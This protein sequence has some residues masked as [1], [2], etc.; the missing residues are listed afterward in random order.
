MQAT[1]PTRSHLK[2]QPGFGYERHKPEESD[3]YQVIAQHWPAFQNQ[4]SEADV[5]LPR[6][7]QTEFQSYL[8]CGLLKH[9]FMRVKCNGCRF[10]HLVAFSCKMR[11]FCPACGA[12]RMVETAAHLIDHVLPEV[13]IRQWVLS[14]PWPLRFLF[15]REPGALSRC[16]T[17]IIR[18]LETDLIKRAGLNRASGAK[19]GTVTLIQRFGSAVNLNIHTHL[20][21]LDGVYTTDETGN[22][23]FHRVKAPTQ[24][25]MDTL[26]ERMVQR[27]I[28]TLERDGW[29]VADE[30][31]PWL[32]LQDREPL[33]SLNAASIQYTIALGPG[34]GNRTLTIH[35]PALVRP[36]HPAKALTSNQNGFSLNAAVAC[37]PHQRDKLERLCRYVTR[38]AICL[39]RLTLRADGQVQYQLK[40][41]FRDGTTHILFSPLDFIGKLVALVPKPRHNL[42]RYHGVLAA[43]AKL[44]KYIV[45]ASVRTKPATKRK[46]DHK[47][48]KPTTDTREQDTPIA[49]L[50]WAQRL[51]RVF[52]IDI[53]I[54]PKCGGRLRII[55]DIT[56]PVVINKI[57]NHIA[58]APPGNQQALFTG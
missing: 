48:D 50:T 12:R 37:Q 10:E 3:L 29:L 16:L 6:F 51:K 11:G 27:V 40:H 28:R 23:K 20:L 41:P 54:C 22:P 57:L 9:G 2:A 19:G 24:K 15:A 13:P 21:V 17:V 7:I 49:P 1:Q 35:N 44:R 52:D 39:E 58:R 56:D 14:F 34:K 53:T 43:N 18:A 30:Q 33:D 5:F 32:D 25:Q 8:R 42:V 55:A 31:Q 36:D 38:P 26:L 46:A 47:K 45:P 4:L